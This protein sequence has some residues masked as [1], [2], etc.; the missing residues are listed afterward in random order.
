VEAVWII[1]GIAI[2][3]LLAELLLPTGGFLAFV[4]AAGLIAAGIVAIGDDTKHADAIGG[5]LIAGGVVSIAAFALISR[6][7]L[8]AH[9]EAPQTGR[10]ELV[11]AEGEVRVGLDPVGQ[12]FVDGALWRAQPADGQSPIATGTR[13][14]IE[15]VDGLTL[16][17]RPASEPSKEN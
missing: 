11:G 6:K 3:L 9:R 12:V 13:V 1:A 2:G 10:E 16:I 8:A 14:R 17:V 7:V 15:S 5:G 4:G